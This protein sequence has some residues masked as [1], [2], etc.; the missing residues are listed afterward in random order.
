MK[1]AFLIVIAAVAL[2]PLRAGPASAA[3]AQALFARALVAERSAGDLKKAIE[4]YGEVVE[5]AGA[6]RNLAARALVRMGAAYETLGVKG[7][8]KAYERVVR[9]YADQPQAAAAARERLEHLEQSGLRAGGKPHVPRS[10]LVWAGME[11]NEGE[12]ST[13]GRYLSLIDWSTGDIAL[14]DLET[15]KVR[16]LTH[17][18]DWS[19]SNDFGGGTRISPDDKT[20]AYTWWD[21]DGVVDLRSVSTDGKSAPRILIHDESLKYVE[22]GPF[23]PDGKRLLVS[24]EPK[25]GEEPLGILDL[26]TLK[27]KILGK[28]P[29]HAHPVAFS[30]DGRWVL[31]ATA[32]DA[33][34]QQRDLYLVASSGGT[35]VPVAPHPSNE[36]GFGFSPD[37]NRILFTSGRSGERGLWEIAVRDGKPLGEPHLLKPAFGTVDPFGISRSGAL[38][39]GIDRGIEDGY[40]VDLG[41]D[42]KA[43][44]RPRHI[45]EIAGQDRLPV[46][47]ADGKQ[48]LFVSYRGA[49]NP[50]RP[51][52]PVY[53]IRDLASGSERALVSKVGPPRRAVTLA[54]SPDG[55]LVA[56]YGTLKPDQEEGT[57]L[58]SLASGKSTRLKSLEWGQPVWSPDGKALYYRDKI[59]ERWEIRVYHPESGAYGVLYAAKPGET[60]GALA[61]TPDGK[62]LAFRKVEGDYAK[63]DIIQTL[64]VKGGEPRDLLREP[65]RHRG[66]NISDGAGMAVTPDGKYLLFGRWVDW[67]SH[68]ENIEL[69]RVPTSGGSS[70]KIGVKLPGIV[71]LAMRPDG[72]QIAFT[73]GRRVEDLWELENM[74]SELRAPTARP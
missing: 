58:V 3:D 45:G 29:H 7:A 64:S 46:W 6:D 72:K 20:V 8:K 21:N 34:A 1:K 57:F 39:Y 16:R 31:F 68:D 33:K 54:P 52:Q 37:G 51:N 41:D 43:R 22:P 69:Y 10:R 55:K 50:N 28:F 11:D 38:Y 65:V 2:I 9:E 60:I 74:L 47:S 4:L 48:L 73:A 15:G 62:R 42:G 23:S 44:G 66:H 63:L 59:D 5:R 35:P 19:V 14:R 18:G 26:E 71:G 13:D 27:L 17:S 12:V 56:V 30:P 24:L 25:K 32:P 70:E 40:I 67:T 49:G 61:I 36:V 53:V